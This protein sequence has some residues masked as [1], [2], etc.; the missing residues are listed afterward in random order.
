MFNVGVAMTILSP[1]FIVIPAIIILY[2]LIKNQL[3]IE[4][5]P[6]NIALF[7]MF[8]LGI[9]SGIINKSL[10]SIIASFG[11][12]IFLLVGIYLQNRL[13]NSHEIENFIKVVW[14]VSL[15]SACIGILEKITS[16]FFDMTWVSQLFYSGPY[17]PSIEDYRIYSTFGNP[18]VTGGWFAI[19]VLVGIYL[20][21][22]EYGKKKKL[23]FISI[24]MFIFCLIFSG[25]K[26]A[27]LGLEAGLIVYAI[28]RKN[29][30][31]KMIILSLCMMVLSLALLSPEINHSLNSRDTVWEQSIQLFIKNPVFG[32]GIFGIIEK[33]KYV[34]AHNIWLSMLT[35]F[36]IIGFTLYLWIKIYIYRGLW[37]LYKTHSEELPLFSSIQAVIVGHGM[38]DFIIMTPQGGMLFFATSIIII[39]MVKSSMTYPM[40]EVENIGGYARRLGTKR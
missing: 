7:L 35:L 2:K 16:Y 25:S 9:F 40:L 19:M 17:V 10:Y 21:E 1:Y 34:H 3:A 14:K 37:I 13:T 32:I 26:G 29:I 18:N 30:K 24:I 5:N 11:L 22:K 36:G 28:L 27:T 8:I 6:L 38:V 15:V 23:Y 39:S 33:T 31:S 12:L 4:L 20:F